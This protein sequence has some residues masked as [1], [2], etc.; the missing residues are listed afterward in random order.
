[1]LSATNHL[2]GFT[3][4]ASDGDIGSVEE[5]Y[6]DDERWTIRYLVADTG[7]WLPGRE[8]L[9]SPMSLGAVNPGAKKLDVKLTKNQVAKSPDIDTH[10]PISRQHEAKLYNYYNYPYY[11]TGPYL[12]GSDSLPGRVPF[13]RAREPGSRNAGGRAKRNVGRSSPQEHRRSDQLLH[14]RIGRRDR[15]RGRLSCR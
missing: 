5:F 12:W 14:S 11:W 15:T 3:L 10:K 2:K 4:R 1:M 8:V 6:F 13:N 9:I 7:K